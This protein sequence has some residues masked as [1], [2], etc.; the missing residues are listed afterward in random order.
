M[1]DNSKIKYSKTT[2]PKI[3]KI[4]SALIANKK[5]IKISKKIKESKNSM[6]SHRV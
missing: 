6:L 1:E 4:K 3:R 5:I 2:A